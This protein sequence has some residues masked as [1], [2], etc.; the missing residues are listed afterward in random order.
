MY[1]AVNRRNKQ[2][3]KTENLAV[4]EL[5][6]VFGVSNV[7]K[8][9]ELG[10][11]IDAIGGVDAIIR[12]DNGDKT[13]QIKPFRDYTVEDGKITMVGTGVIKQ[14]KTDMLVFHNKGRGIMVFDNNNTQ[15]ENGEY[16]FDEESQYKY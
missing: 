13:V 11:V 12:T 3:D 5:Q 7:K 2:G 16:V 9:G 6:K 8:V 15:I 1:T 10:S 14:Y 4:K